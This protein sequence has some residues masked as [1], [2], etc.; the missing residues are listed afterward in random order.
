MFY[1][2]EPKLFKI[3]CQKFLSMKETDIKSPN[4][5]TSEA[6]SP[7]IPL[8][9]EEMDYN[10]LNDI[11]NWIIYDID[12]KILEDRIKKDKMELRRKRG[13][14]KTTRIL[15]AFNNLAEEDIFP[16]GV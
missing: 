3:L 15:A 5:V 13:I 9:A 12:S 4:Q 2:V 11:L 6:Y 7:N 14:G 1:G 8:R 10:L 16:A